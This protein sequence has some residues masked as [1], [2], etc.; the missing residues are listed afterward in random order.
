M[1]PKSS[2]TSRNRLCRTITTRPSQLSL[3][4]QHRLR[5]PTTPEPTV[6]CSLFTKGR[7]CNAEVGR[8]IWRDLKCFGWG[9]GCHTVWDAVDDAIC[10]W[11]G[12]PWEQKRKERL[13]DWASE[14]NPYE[15][16]TS[17]TQ[18]SECRQSGRGIDQKK[19]RWFCQ[20]KRNSC[21]FKYVNK[22]LFSMPAEVRMLWAEMRNGMRRTESD[23][24][25][26]FV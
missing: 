7:H 18:K 11:A 9:R 26:I 1:R 24:D 17:A 13:V 6:D 15:C 21:G 25:H 10:K 16:N 19:S 23:G 14:G 4:L 8:C 2:E 20:W 5:E 22:L 12:K 3:N